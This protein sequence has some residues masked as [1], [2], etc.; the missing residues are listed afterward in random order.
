[1]NPLSDLKLEQWL[2]GELSAEESA[3][4]EAEINNNVSL[5]TR[6]EEMKA[7]T[8]ALLQQHT[9]EQFKAEVERKVHRAKVREQHEKTQRSSSVN[10][11]PLVGVAAFGLAMLILNPFSEPVPER[12]GQGQ[13]GYRTK[14]ETMHLMAHRIDADTQE[15]LHD[16]GMAQAGDRIQLSIAKAKGLAFVVFSLDG[17]GLISEHYPQGAAAEIEE[18]DFLSLPS[19]YRLDDAPS[20]EDFY[21]ISSKE[22][23]DKGLVLQAA[24][25][26]KNQPD[27]QAALQSRL[28]PELKI[29][30]ISLK[31]GTQ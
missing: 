31:K 12:E 30:R 22:V 27:F 5:R 28:P 16:G 29:N 19:S 20:F 15:Q 4:I 9:P 14:G 26:A 1:M 21:L 17:N 2:L 6:V 25:E 8:Q 11:K 3:T 24:K 13:G 7:H 23:L 10:W 18:M